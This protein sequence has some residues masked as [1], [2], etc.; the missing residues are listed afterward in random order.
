MSQQEDAQIIALLKL[1]DPDAVAYWLQTYERRLYRFF[2]S[3]VSHP[4]DAQELTQDTFMSCLKHLP[5]FRGD[6]KIWTWMMSVARHEVSDYFRKKYAKRALQLLPLSELLLTTK[7]ESTEELAD[8]VGQA[9]SRMSAV[10]RE[11]LLQKYVDGKRVAVI[12]AEQDQSEKSIES[13]LYR[14]R[15]EFRE[16]FVAVTTV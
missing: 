9:L 6:S 1:G 12:A 11:L 13:Q 14:A 7:L 15:L 3:K 16:Q 4:S 10:S 8:Q 2:L 5:L